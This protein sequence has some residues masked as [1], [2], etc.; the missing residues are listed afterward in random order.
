MNKTKKIINSLAAL[1]GEITVRAVKEVNQEDGCTCIEIEVDHVI[2][3]RPCPHCGSKKHKKYGKKPSSAWH[4]PQ[5]K[6]IPTHII[7]RK[8]RF[9]CKNCGSTY[10]E[11]I[12]W[13]YEDGHLTSALAGCMI[14]DLHSIMTKDDVA[15]INGVSVYYVDYILEKVKP[16]IPSH[17]PAVICLDETF[18]QVEEELDDKTAWIRFVTNFSDGETGELLDILP[19]RNK[20]QLIHYFND[21]FSYEE[22]SKVKHLCCDG[23][24]FYMDLADKCFPHADVCLDNFHIT[25][26]LH[27][28]FF[29]VGTKRQ[30]QLLSKS[31]EKNDIYFKEAYNL[32]RLS[33]KFVTSAHNHEYYWADKYDEYTNRIK[34]HLSLCPELKD[35]YAMVQYYYEIFHGVDNYETKI[36]NLSTWISIFGKS[37]SE[38]IADTVKAVTDRL[39]YIHN[40]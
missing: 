7:Y 14:T 24:D 2:H 1:S 29:H 17:L 13:I 37:T 16:P 39:E 35:A 26:R 28:G 4:I 38:A 6:R 9:L 31:K 12:T 20:R 27:K 8:Q 36:A 40:A 30:E 23:A 22:R 3:T 15:R 19:F 21:N 25:K 33:H 10:L 32:K 11:E 18:S 34:H 5:G